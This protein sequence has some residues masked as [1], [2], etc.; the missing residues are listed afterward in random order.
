MKSVSTFVHKTGAT[1][2][3]SDLAISVHDTLPL[4]GDVAMA[5]DFRP[6]TFGADGSCVLIAHGFA[7]GLNPL[8]CNLQGWG[9]S[10]GGTLAARYAF[11]S[12]SNPDAV[13]IALSKLFELRAVPGSNSVMEGVEPNTPP[14]PFLLGRG[15]VELV[16][17]DDSALEPG[18]APTQGVRLTRLGLDSMLIGTALCVLKHVLV[19]P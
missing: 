17:I 3:E 5:P 11:P 2:R 15:Y 19:M 4:S 12:Q 1:L 14:W 7:T 16:T 10:S 6:R 18:G 8:A 9:T 13:H